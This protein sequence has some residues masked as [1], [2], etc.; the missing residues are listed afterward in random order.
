MLND[1]KNNKSGKRVIVMLPLDTLSGEVELVLKN[2]GVKTE[3]III[4]R[5]KT[6]AIVFFLL[7]N[8][9]YL[10]FPFPFVSILL[11]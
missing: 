1:V 9:L 6:I 11:F 8:S 5:I 3:D 4:A 2:Y 10:I 7:L